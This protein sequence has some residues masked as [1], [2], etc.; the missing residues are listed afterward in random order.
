MKVRLALLVVVIGGLSCSVTEKGSIAL[1]WNLDDPDP[2]SEPDASSPTTITISAI[3]VQ[4]ADGGSSDD[5]AIPLLESTYQAGGT[6]TLPSLDGFDIDVMEATLFNSASAPIIFGRTIPVQ[7]AGI[8]NTTLSIFVQRTGQFAR[9][10]SSFSVFPES[11]LALAIENQYILVADGSG[12]SDASAAQLYDMN[13]WAPIEA[14]TALPCAPLSIAPLGGTLIAILCVPDNGGATLTSSDV[15]AYG[16]DLN[17]I[18][19]TQALPTFPPG[20]GWGDVAGGAT[21]LAPNGDSFIVGGTRPAT[22]LGPTNCV[23]RVGQAGTTADAGFIPGTQTA[24]T[25]SAMRQGA[26][27]T[28]SPTYGL[29]VAGGNQSSADVPVEYLG[30]TA[31]GDAGT[32]PAPQWPG[33]AVADL[34]QGSGAAVVGAMTLVLAGGTLPDNSVAGVRVFNL[35]CSEDCDPEPE[36]GAESKVDGGSEVDGGDDA[37]E[38]GGADAGMGLSV[39]LGIAR[40]FTVG[41]SSALFVGA[42]G[43]GAGGVTQAFLLSIAGTSVTAVT[44][45]PLQVTTRTATTSIVSPV[46]SVLVIGGDLTMESFFP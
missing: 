43:P 15:I 12:K 6:L 31:D 11:P 32:L 3:S 36:A 9:L 17:H 37:G 21:V 40:G 42:T 23:V 25:F 35:M 20:C 4:S 22:I 18:V 13:V 14:T 44:G 41:A 28:W 33:Y 10:P 5:A 39:P 45:V 8:Q 38:E 2:F 7:L 27:A 46:T 16:F 24:G 30:A 26:A 29:V 1:I 34:A 19:E